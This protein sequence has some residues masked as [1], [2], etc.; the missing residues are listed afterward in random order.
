MHQALFTK[1]MQEADAVSETVLQ[2]NVREFIVKILD[3]YTHK[4]FLKI[5]F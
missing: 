2:K 1:T 5:P 3:K 4:Q